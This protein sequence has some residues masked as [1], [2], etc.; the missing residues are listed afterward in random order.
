M[1]CLR[2]PEISKRSIS[3]RIL[4]P[5]WWIITLTTCPSWS[6]P[7]VQSWGRPRPCLRPTSS[8]PWRRTSGGPHRG[9]LR[10]PRA[11]GWSHRPPG[12]SRFPGNHGVRCI[13]AW[14][15]ATHNPTDI[16]IFKKTAFKESI[17][18]I[19]L[20]Q[21]TVL[22]VMSRLN[23]SYLLLSTVERSS[24]N[25]NNLDLHRKIH[26]AW[27]I[28]SKWICEATPGAVEGSEIT[29][30]VGAWLAFFCRAS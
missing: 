27:Q 23:P 13:V 5:Y 7:K 8:C 10:W 1:A 14:N 3:G 15:Q 25:S 19:C 21:C 4:V 28:S 11:W 17:I 24:S 30:P 12:E 29:L 6:P 22:Y 16:S 2:L 26:H 18:Y 20:A 9:P